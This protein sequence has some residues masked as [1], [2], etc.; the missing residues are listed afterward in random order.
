[1]SEL[2]GKGAKTAVAEAVREAGPLIVDE[3][4]QL[5]LLPLLGGDQLADM[6][7][8]QAARR[9][10]VQSAKRGRAT[11]SQNTLTTKVR[12]VLL[13]RYGV[14]P[15]EVLFQTFSRPT[16]DLA[17]QLG[18]KNEE[19]YKLQLLAARE[20]LPYVQGKAPLEVR[21]DGPTAS[22]TF[23]SPEAALAVWAAK[24]SED[25]GG[26][27]LDAPDFSVVESQEDGNA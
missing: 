24:A 6:P 22:F 14:H 23:V 20:A 15:L 11:G 21:V 17:V 7:A 16:E 2:E 8:D 4:V 26:I 27:L 25:T 9:Q 5:G 13:K 10:A 12:A 1:M 18:C 3:P 19:A